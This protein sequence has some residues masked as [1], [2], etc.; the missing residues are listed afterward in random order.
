MSGA[1]TGFPV[2]FRCSK[3]KNG[4]DWR[5]GE[6]EKGTNVRLTGETKPLSSSQLG[7]GNPRAMNIR[8][9]YECLDCGHVGWSRHGMMRELRDHRGNTLVDWDKVQAAMYRGKTGR[10]QPGDQKLCELAIAVDVLRYRTFSTKV[11]SDVTEK[12]RN[13]GVA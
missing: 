12:M 3:C 4:R 5:G 7:K 2:T 1:G 10:A 8:A 11:V 9:Q 13:G 6:S